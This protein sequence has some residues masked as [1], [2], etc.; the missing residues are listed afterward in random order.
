MNCPRCQGLMVRDD[1]LDLQDETGQYGFVAW[2][3]LI[4][5]EVLDPVILKHR[6][7]PSEPIT[8]RARVPMKVQLVASD[9]CKPRGF[10]P[11]R[12]LGEDPDRIMLSGVPAGFIDR[13]NT[14]GT[15]L[16]D[17]DM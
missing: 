9:R 12:E 6:N 17:V 14:L 13:E 15:D 3:C 8:G 11:Y 7:A 16:G 10:D 5:G 1:F 4:C 2:R